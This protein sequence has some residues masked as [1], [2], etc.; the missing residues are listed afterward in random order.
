MSVK[1]TRKTWD[2]YVILKARDVIKLLGRSVPAEQAVKVLND[3]TTCEIIKVSTIFFYVLVLMYH[4]FRLRVWL[5]IKVYQSNAD[6]GL[7]ALME[8]L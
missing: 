4:F 1:T 8:Q 3:N 6:K 5:E 7:L 2:P